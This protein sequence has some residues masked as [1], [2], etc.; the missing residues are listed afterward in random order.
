MSTSLV[1][2]YRTHPPQDGHGPAGE[3]EWQPVEFFP[4]ND[5]TPSRKLEPYFESESE[6]FVLAAA[7]R[8][9]DDDIVVAL[10]DAG[11]TR[12]TLPALQM[13]PVVF[14]AWASDAVTDE[15][16]KAVI[17]SVH[18]SRLFQNPEAASRVQ[19]WLDERPDPELWDLWI[20]YTQ[21]R[22]EQTP[23]M[24]RRLAG[25]RVLEH[26]TQVALASGGF[27][28]VGKICET[29]QMILDGIRTVYGL[30]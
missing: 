25:Q 14:A 28:G 22:L 30:R 8:I 29:E 12:E 15:E 24:I 7:A 13:V 26:A 17:W 23:S 9:D 27:L 1:S 16:C 6:R 2:R 18:E 20:A 5:H 11:F 19:S 3:H 10:L 21:R 4:V